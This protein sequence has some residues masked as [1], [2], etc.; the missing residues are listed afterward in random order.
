MPRLS[1]RLAAGASLLAAFGIALAAVLLAT[2]QIAFVNTHGVSMNPVYYQG[3]LVVVS[4]ATEY[5]PGDIAAY[6]LA[7][8]D[9]ALHRII[10][11]NANGFTFKGD[12]NESVDVDHPRAGDLI[13]RAVLHIPHGGR[14]LQIITS[15]PV[16][17]LA[18]F[19]LLA[20]AAPTL[21]RRRRR[22]AARKETMTPSAATQKARHAL[23][24][25][26]EPPRTVWTGTAAA[27]AV[28]A[29]GLGAWAWSGPADTSALAGADARMD[30]SYS[31]DVPRTPAYDGT[32]VTSPDPVFRRVTD[33]I[34]V[35]YSYQGPSATITPTAELSTPGG[36]HTSIPL[37]DP[38]DATSGTH[39]GTVRLDIAALEARANQ[40]AKVTGLPANPLTIEVVPAVTSKDQTFKPAL[41]LSVTALQVSPVDPSALSVTADEAQTPAPRALSVGKWQLTAGAAR[42]IA[43]LLLGLALAALMGLAWASA[44]RPSGGEAETIQHRW[45]SLVVPVHPMPTP[46]GRPVIDVMDFPTLAKLAERYGLL[47]LHWTR[48]DVETFIVQDDNTTYRY[49]TGEAP[50]EHDAAD[51]LDAPTSRKN[52]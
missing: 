46:V 38:V 26:L 24:G 52:T 15:P 8:G 37:G 11:A 1:R 22:R 32:T 28:V 23:R 13:G 6:H 45:P 20:G 35:H 33:A 51:E 40:A 12:N 43:P 47:V 30:F 3:D 19:A 17:G 18:A 31:A 42:T 16:L 34:E 41:E 36:W 10:D 2:G 7:D 39:R 50:I 4:R 25:M 48:S 27:L 5:S 44:R 9:V 29:V 14:L 21:T 49:R